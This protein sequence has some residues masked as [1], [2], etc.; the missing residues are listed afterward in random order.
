MRTLFRPFL[1]SLVVLFALFVLISEDHTAPSG[2]GLRVD[3]ER[4][5]DLGEGLME[6]LLLRY[7]RQ[8]DVEAS[9]IAEAQQLLRQNGF[10]SGPVDGTMNERTREALRSFQESRQLNVTGRIDNDTAQELGLPQRMTQKGSAR[11]NNST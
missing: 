5:S 2:S 4:S 3:G 8:S 1:A 11:L 6:V 9:N 10:Y 7:Q